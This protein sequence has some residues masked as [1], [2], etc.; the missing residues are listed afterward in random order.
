MRHI[1][2]TKYISPDCKLPS[3]SVSIPVYVDSSLEWECTSVGRDEDF[4][5]S[6]LRGQRISKQIVPL[7]SGLGFSQIVKVVDAH[8]YV[9]RFLQINGPASVPE[10]LRDYGAPGAERFWID[11][12]KYELPPDDISPVPKPRK[13]RH[14]VY[15]SELLAFQEALLTASATPIERWS[16]FEDAPGYLPLFSVRYVPPVQIELE[17]DIFVGACVGDECWE[18]CLACVFFDRAQD[19]ELR[20][21]ARISCPRVFRHTSK[22]DRIFC[23]DECSHYMAVRYSRGL[24]KP[25][26]RRVNRSKRGR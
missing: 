19:I 25:L 1:K 17:D 3:I 7:P 20:R 23:S 2:C 14:S 10:F 18:Q 13:R 6:P 16:D 24:A 11:L 4:L 22:H 5:F 21:C 12:A 9:D 15:W 26:S 8:E